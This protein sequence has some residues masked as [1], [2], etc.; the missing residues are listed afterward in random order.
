MSL[1]RLLQFSKPKTPGYGLS[2]S[3]YFSILS[4]H[5]QLPRPDQ[6]AS[7]SGESGTVAGFIAPLMSGASKEDLARP[8]VRGVYALASKDRKTVLRMHVVSK[9]EAGFD[10]EPIASS[11]VALTLSEEALARI[12]GTW[13]LLQLTFESHDPMVAESMRFLFDVSRRLAEL[14]DGVIADPIAQRYLLPAELP[15]LA[16]GAPISA[17]QH[18]TI[19]MAESGGR[20]SIFTLGMQKFGLA[21]FE[22][23]EIG[24]GD[25]PTAGAF[26]LSLGQAR[27]GGSEM[28]PGDRVGARS[29]PFDVAVGGLDRARW[30][31]IPVFE[32]LPSRGKTVAEALAAWRAEAG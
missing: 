10:P 27:F 29:A 31:G 3:F 19:R 4:S 30:E 5:A 32:L 24:A 11:P 15:Q 8:L 17:P 12:R 23:H 1:K 2:K 25:E 16:E 13:T 14:T 20:P 7:P 26:L 6:I 22:L 28:N 18:L 21:E 9:E